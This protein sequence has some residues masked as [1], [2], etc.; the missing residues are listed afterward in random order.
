MNIVSKPLLNPRL[1]Q[2]RGRR[3]QGRALLLLVKLLQ[4]CNDI[5]FGE[6]AR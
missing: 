6:S 2:S 4:G 3:A 1:N 5:Q